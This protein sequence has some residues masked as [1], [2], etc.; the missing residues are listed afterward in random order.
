MQ[1]T[2]VTATPSA[3][4]FAQCVNPCPVDNLNTANATA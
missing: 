4:M 1:T 3:A 2:K